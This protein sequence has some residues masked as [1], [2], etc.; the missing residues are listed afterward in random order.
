MRRDLHEATKLE[1][2]YYESI[3]E[4]ALA[5]RSEPKLVNRLVTKVQLIEELMAR[6]KSE[7]P[8]IGVLVA[9][10]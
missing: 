1:E 8:R 10:W 5:A 7:E 9:R 6:M 4:L 2:L 3:Q